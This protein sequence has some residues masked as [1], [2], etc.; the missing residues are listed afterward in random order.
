MMRLIANPY[1]R[2]AP[3]ETMAAHRVA[4]DA[5]PALALLSRCPAYAPTPLASDPDLASQFGVGRLSLKDERARMGLGS[6]KALGAAYV[7]ASDAAGRSAG[8]DTATLAG[9]TYVCASAGNHGL[10]MA[11]GA[12]VFGA[13]AV[14]YLARTVPESFAER[15][16]GKGAE[17]VREGERYEESMAAALAAA[18]AN[19]WTLLSDS[20]WPGYEDIPRRVMEGY[21]AMAE[22]AALALDPPPTHLFLQAGVGGLAAAVAAHARARWGDAPL[23]IVVEPELA[24]CLATSIEAGRPVHAGAGESSMGRLDCKEPSMLALGALARDADY[25]AQIS[26]REAAETTEFLRANGWS[27]TPSA[28][29]GVAALR[30]AAS[31]GPLGLSPDSHALAFLSEMADGG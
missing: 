15:L 7:I 25:F 8:P 4:S 24:P 3:P 29:A 26:E 11:A 12:R 19:G 6:F 16:R 10:S 13:R 18:E 14:V 1:R 5:A 20:S 23:I 30:H 27:A 17:V 31:D 28:T 21:L 2:S 22:E 9:Q